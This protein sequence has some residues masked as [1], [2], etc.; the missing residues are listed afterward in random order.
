MEA[1]DTERMLFLSRSTHGG[2]GTGSGRGRSARQ[3][4]GTAVQEEAAMAWDTEAATA[5]D[6]EAATS[7]SS[8]RE[9]W[10]R[11]TQRGWSGLLLH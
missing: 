2:V 3:A 8:G 7:N 6:A 4:F 11:G 10:R 9:Q 5:R 1:R